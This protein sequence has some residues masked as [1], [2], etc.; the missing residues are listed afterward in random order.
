MSG[1]PDPSGERAVS[2]GHGHG[3]FAVRVL[4]AVGIAALA[5]AAWELS[6][7]PRRSSWC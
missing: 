1:L 3:R 5:L 7:V 4:I 2:H 6:S